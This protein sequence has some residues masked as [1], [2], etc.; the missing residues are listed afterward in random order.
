MSEHGEGDAYLDNRNRWFQYVRR[1]PTRV[2]GFYQ[3]NRIRV[4]LGTKDPIVGTGEAR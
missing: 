2:Q 3:S 4:S 1:I